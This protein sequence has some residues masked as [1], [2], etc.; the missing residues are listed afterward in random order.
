MT[1]P[2]PSAWTRKIWNRYMYSD[3]EDIFLFKKLANGDKTA[4]EILYRKYYGLMMNY[5]LKICSD[6]DIVKDCIQDVFVRI[7]GNVRI[8]NGKRLLPRAYL[9]ASLR[10][11]LFDSLSRNSR[12]DSIDMLDFS[13]SIDEGRLAELLKNDD[14]QLSKSIAL[15]K[16]ISALSTRSKM[17]LYLK[18]ICGFSHKEIALALGIKEQSSMNLISRILAALK[19]KISK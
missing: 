1:A 15:V 7:F 13:V 2:S 9:L 12:I 16:Y 19:E 18:F 14:E 3:E 4:L 10:N 11:A 8:S 5:G 17:A 6:K